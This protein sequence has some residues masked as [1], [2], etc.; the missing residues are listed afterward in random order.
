MKI[1]LAKFGKILISRPSGHE[2]FLAIKAYFAPKS[3]Q[4]T[5]ELDFTGVDVIAPSWLDEVLNG[6]SSEYGC[7]RVRI[8]QSQNLSLIESLKTLEWKI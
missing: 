5:I 1:P 4:E 2:A 6:L 7:D 3:N 8:I